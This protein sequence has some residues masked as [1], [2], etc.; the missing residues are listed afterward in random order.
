MRTMRMMRR[1]ST[2]KEVR[3]TE[4]YDECLGMV[5]EGPETRVEKCMIE[6]LGLKMREARGEW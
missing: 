2:V 6:Q 5:S 3:T 1:R 4:P